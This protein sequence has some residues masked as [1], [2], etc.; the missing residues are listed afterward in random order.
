MSI[1]VQANWIRRLVHRKAAR[2]CT[3]HLLL[4]LRPTDHTDFTFAWVVEKLSQPGQ[5]S[6]VTH[7]CTNRVWRRAPL[8]CA[9]ST[10][11]GFDLA[12]FCSPSS[13][14]LYIFGLHAIYK[15]KKFV[16]HSL[17][18][19]LV[20]WAWW[21]WPL[22]WLTTTIV[23]QCCDTVGWVMKSSQKWPIICW[24]GL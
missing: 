14:H 2:V 12:W 19:R 8:D 5:R 23:L 1:L 7:P 15:F 21:D 24:V 11:S 6:V 22:T 16:L 13:K 10:I 20:S 18:Y 9:E 4:L 17:L 3:H